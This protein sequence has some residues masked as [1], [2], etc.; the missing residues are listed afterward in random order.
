MMM[1]WVMWV[2][3]RYSV[4]VES[5]VVE[6]IESLRQPLSDVELNK[7]SKQDATH[8]ETDA[9]TALLNHFTQKNTDALVKCIHSRTSSDDCIRMP[10]SNR[11]HY[12]SCP[13]VRQS[14]CFSVC[15]SVRPY[16]LLTRNQRGI[17][18]PKLMLT[19]PR[20]GVNNRLV[21]FPWTLKCVTL[22][23]LEMSFYAEDYFCVGLTRFFRVAFRD[24]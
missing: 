10:A 17:D 16:G 18:K 14:V 21:G 6:L 2:M 9:Y 15:L 4:N 11:R 5:A 23:A 7:M 3:C 22:N 1:A 12:M 20:A 19:S 8:H 24:I 13:S